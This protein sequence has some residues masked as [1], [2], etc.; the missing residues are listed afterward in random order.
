MTKYFIEKV[1][2][3]TWLQEPEWSGNGIWTNDPMKAMQFDSMYDADEYIKR[4]SSEPIWSDWVL[5][6]G[7]L[8]VTEHEFVDSV[9]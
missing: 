4:E 2:D 1:S 9:G 5:F 7:E 6:S 3:N 8:I